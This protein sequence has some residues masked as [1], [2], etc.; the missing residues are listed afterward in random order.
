MMPS[1][2]PTSAGAYKKPEYAYHLL[3][4]ALECFKLSANDLSEQQ[5]LD[6]SIIADRTWAL[7]S[8]V[9][10]SPEALGATVT[11]ADVERA[12]A[13]IGSRYSDRTAYLADIVNN[14]LDET[15]LR[16]ALRRELLFDAVMERVSLKTPKVNELDIQIFYQLHTDR[17][18]RPETRKAR[19][20][21]ITVNPDYP[22]NEYQRVLE[23]MQPLVAKL[24]RNPARFKDLARTHSECPTALEGGLLG[25]VPMGKLYPE[26][27]TALFAM[28][29]G[30]ISDII[31]TEMGMHI[32]YCEKIYASVKTPLSRAKDRI[33]GILEKRQ[34]KAC[35]Q[36]WLDKLREDVA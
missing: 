32:L 36:A 5:Y 8:I 28:A 33:R 7:E 10:S 22:E 29:Q 20:I 2:Q 27:D 25:E 4:A 21:L 31:E 13:Q 18:I 9:L 19:H 15:I 14:G 24:R 17:F 34:R 12:V 23:R 26:L 1:V 3:R 6:T 11:D 30:E 16:T 35:Q